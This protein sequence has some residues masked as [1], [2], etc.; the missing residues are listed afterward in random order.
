MNMEELVEAYLAIRKEREKL[1]A[2]FEAA[3]NALKGDLKELEI[4]MLKSC[5]ELNA[6]SIN[7]AHGTVIRKLEER[8]FCSDWENFY[9]FVREQN[10]PELLEK[11][12]HQKNFKTFLEEHKG[13][14]LPPGV[15]LMR[16]YGVTVR[17]SSKEV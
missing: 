1:A 7:T 14:G 15:N 3:D 13:E 4:F 6:N 11:R 5:N 16:E 10:S 9:N 17:K 12:I 8:Y 2:Q